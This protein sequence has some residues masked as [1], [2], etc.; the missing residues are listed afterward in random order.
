MGQEGHG[1]GD[2]EPVRSAARR[3][4]DSEADS[5]AAAG[6]ESGLDGSSVTLM[7]M[8]RCRQRRGVEA[9]RLWRRAAGMCMQA[10]VSGRRAGRPNN[11]K[12]R[13]RKASARNAS[14]ARK[15]RL[16]EPC[17]TVRRR[18][19]QVPTLSRVRE[20]FSVR[21]PGVGGGRDRDL[22]WAMPVTRRGRRDTVSDSLTAG[23]PEPGPESSQVAAVLSRSSDRF[24]S[25]SRSQS[26]LS[27]TS[28]WPH[29]GWPRRCHGDFDGVTSHRGSRA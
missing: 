26:R 5:L 3:P 17:A 10:Q 15:G 21:C 6:P 20:F 8:T 16:S 2:S 22:A 27:P 12:V 1:L 23:E 19:I 28:Q 13:I 29:S 18:V 25:R 7:L 24:R 4:R 14:Q 11:R 9:Q